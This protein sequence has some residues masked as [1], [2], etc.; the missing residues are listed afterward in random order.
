MTDKKSKPRTVILVKAAPALGLLKTPT[1]S[2]DNNNKCVWQNCE[3]TKKERTRHRVLVR[4][5]SLI[6]C[7]YLPK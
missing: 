6:K 7:S 5:F 1:F 3:R 4:S 2:P